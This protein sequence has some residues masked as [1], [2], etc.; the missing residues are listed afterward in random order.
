MKTNRMFKKVLIL[1]SAVLLAAVIEICFFNGIKMY[2]SRNN[3]G[4]FSL[5]NNIEMVIEEIEIEVFDDNKKE[6]NLFSLDNNN[7][8]N[9]RLKL[10]TKEV[11]VL[12]I[13]TD[14]MYMDRIVINYD[15]NTDV[16]LSLHIKKFDEYGNPIY[17]DIPI[18]FLKE[19]NTLTKV[20]ESDASNMKIQLNYDE[21]INLNIF[22]ISVKNEFCFNLYRF[23]LM[24]I[25]F[26]TFAVLFVLRKII[27]KKIEY[28]F[29]IIAMCTG[30]SLIFIIPCLTV[31]SWDD[32]IYLDNMYSLFESGEVKTSKAFDYSRNLKLN[33]N[34]VPNSYEEFNNIYN[35]LN[36][37][38]NVN[39][40]GM[41]NENKYISYDKYS[42]LPS[43]TIIWLGKILKLPYTMIF[44][45]GKIMNLLVYVTLMF[46]AIKNAKIGKKL[47]FV[48]GLLPSTI[49][50][51]SQ[52]SRDTI[53][54]AGIYLA[55]STF[56]NCYCTNEKMNRKNL[57]IFVFSV[58]IACSSKAIYI[59]YLLLLILLPN[60]K[61]SEKTNAKWI[62]I[63]I[64][65]LF[66]ISMSTF[67]L[68]AANSTPGVASDVR[69][70]NSST[71]SQIE[72]I[73]NQPISFI[74]VFSKFVINELSNQFT[75]NQSL[76]RWHNFIV[77]DGLK[78]YVMLAIIL[79]C[80]IC[81]DL[82]EKTERIDK[83]LRISLIAITI[84]VTC[85]ICGSMY[86]SYT[87]VGY[88][89]ITGVQ[90]RYYI[91]LLFGFYIVFKQNKIKNNMNSELVMKFISIILL[92]I[93]LSMIYYGIFVNVG[94]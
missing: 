84:F 42:Y 82:G 37:N 83:K 4:V 15:T 39:G 92:C 7:I 62:K 17:E 21:N 93:Y 58:L 41:V 94:L 67:I 59:P 87:P 3:R 46:F 60:N 79:L 24:S 38:S 71:G 53:I 91:P 22:D 29:V 43:A 80:S 31:Y 57:L 61:F 2:E 52:Y 63:L 72:I 19:F 12:K 34:N 56:L 23:I 6:K 32:H 50:L 69:G 85:L 75:Y 54:T 27:F 33:I 5:K 40:I 66:V 86:L 88:S 8:D 1:M 74:K 10:E 25:F 36:A 28:L 81:S 30:L 68:P 20:I 13:K 49:F 73:K 48:L 55:I 77:I 76:G 51:A 89:T 65:L 70:G 90:S 14:K 26:I 11:N 45:L 18:T 35:Y 44:H 78:Y 9:E 16:E 64:L 47:L